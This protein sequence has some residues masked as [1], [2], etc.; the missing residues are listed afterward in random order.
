MKIKSSHFDKSVFEEKLQHLSH[1]DFSLFIECSPQSQEELSS[2]NIIS[3]QEPNEYFG[4]HDWTIQNKHLFNFIL[5]Q[6]DKVLNNCDNAIFQP[7]GHTWLKPNQ[8]NINHNKE[9]KLSHLQG[10]LLKTYGH[11]LRHQV[12]LRKNELNIPLKFYETYGDRNNIEDARLGKEFIF[13][14]SQFGVVVENTSSRGYFTEKI[15]DCFLLKTIPIYWGCSNIGDF[16]DIRGIIPF[17]NVDDLVYISNNL[18]EDYYNS[19]KEIID[20]NWK[21]ALEYVHYEQNISNTIVNI[22]KHNNLI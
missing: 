13:G 10:K 3:F 7:F 16:F 5:T 1:L 9:F 17:N 22:F 20:K 19:K 8:Y 18:N 11:S 12:T 21:L 6:S 14:D 4:L 15:L 2:I